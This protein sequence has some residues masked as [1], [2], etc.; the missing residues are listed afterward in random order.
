MTQGKHSINNIE[1]AGAAETEAGQA[2]AKHNALLVVLRVA[3]FLVLALAVFI[4]CNIAIG[5]EGSGQSKGAYTAFDDLPEDS[6]DAV[7][8]GA[9]SVSR[10]FNASKAYADEGI[11][12]FVFGP[13]ATP[14]IFSDNIMQLAQETQK[15]KV[16]VIELRNV[17][18][19]YGAVYETS[20]RRTVD[21][22]KLS[23]K[24]RYDMIEEGLAAL[25]EHAKEGSYDDS[26]IDYVFPVVKYHSRATTGDKDER[27]DTED[28]VLKGPYN[29]TQGFFYSASTVTQVPQ[30]DPT[31]YLDSAE[32]DGDIKEILDGVIDYC[33][34][35]D[36]QVVF[37]FSPYLQEQSEAEAANAVTDYVESRGYTCLN[38]NTLELAEA[39]GVDYATDFYNY[40]HVNY[41][42]SEAYTEYMAKY[43]KEHYDLPDHRGDSAYS[44][45]EK[46]Y[47]AYEKYVA[48]GIKYVS[49]ENVAD[50]E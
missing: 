9:S 15:P 19:G 30:P 14:T 23:K 34:T 6:V 21:S 18:K 35:T 26:Y 20:V 13:S 46:G 24:E 29:K 42:G 11:S 36:A 17:L 43:L 44:A 16:Y 37:T 22:I 7:F 32:L 33:D 45:W 4:Y 47:E 31:F 38:F 40:H 2:V 10:Y 5:Y 1:G 39:C 3:V 25:R 50:D 8:V 27:I 28:L 12:S 41:L 48:D 49:T